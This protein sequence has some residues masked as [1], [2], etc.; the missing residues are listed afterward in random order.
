L[1][2][3]PAGRRRELAENSRRRID[4]WGPGAFA[5]GMRQAVEVALR[6][7]APKAS[8]WDKLLL[9]LLLQL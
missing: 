3:M 5:A 1:S 8:L 4:Q 6:R 2:Q 7:P 9:R